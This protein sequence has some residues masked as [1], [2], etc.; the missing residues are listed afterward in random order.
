MWYRP[1]S[2]PKNLSGLF[3]TPSGKFE[4][5]SK[6]L[7]Q[8]IQDDSTKNIGIAATGDEACMAHY[9]AP[10]V[11]VDRSMYP[12]LMLPYEMINLAS[13]WIPSPPFLYKTIFENQLLKD[14]S[15]AAV[16]PRTAAKYHLK[17][18]DLVTVKSPVGEVQVRI[19]LFEGA[20]PGIVYLPLGFG[21]TAYDEFLKAK[22][23]NPNN[24]VQAGKDP[25]S[26]DPVWWNTPV[27][28]MKV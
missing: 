11:G 17:E 7:E 18:G 4:F 28:L 14:K 24:I 8:A 26:G 5:F 12:L 20:M 27:R 2:P 16:N 22:G 9:E 3:K 10:K 6:T 1:V 23:V 25:V 13:G 19:N 15:F 21:H